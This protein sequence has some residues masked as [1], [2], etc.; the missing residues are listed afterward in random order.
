[1][2]CAKKERK[3]DCTHFLKI[4][5]AFGENRQ[6]RSVVPTLLSSFLLMLKGKKKEAVLEFKLSMSEEKLIRGKKNI[7][8]VTKMHVS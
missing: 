8:E 5:M 6:G 2:S 1:M 4:K 7:S 3:K